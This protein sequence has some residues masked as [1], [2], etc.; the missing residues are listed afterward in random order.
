MTTQ[1]L[2]ALGFEK[3]DVAILPRLILSISAREKQG[4][5]H[6]ALTAPGPIAFFNTDIGIEG[7]INKFAPRKEIMIM[8]MPVPD[9]QVE[10]KKCWEKFKSAYDSV[11]RMKDVR[12]V[13]LDTATEVWELLRMYK[14]G[15]L[16]QVMPHQYGPVNAIY[17]RMLKDSYA[18]NKNIILL[19]K[20]KPVYIDDKRTNKYERAG[21][22]DT[23]YIVQ[24]NCIMFRDPVTKENP[25]PQFNIQIEDSRHNPDVVGMKFSGA[26]CNFPMVA[27]MILGE[28]DWGDG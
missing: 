18:S 2:A 10:A 28:G 27:S 26:M 22:S 3:P 5:T 4:K 13:V 14:F 9:S 17:R 21:F 19:H 1:Q 16:S 23:G 25:N 11:L 24:A 15:K 20:M 7:V 6:F 12:T 8:N